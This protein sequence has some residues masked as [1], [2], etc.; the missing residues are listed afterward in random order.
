MSD[1]KGRNRSYVAFECI[2]CYLGLKC[3][4]WWTHVIE[5]LLRNVNIKPQEMNI[6]FKKFQP[7]KFELTGEVLNIFSEGE[8]I[9]MQALS[10][11]FLHIIGIGEFNNA[12]LEFH[13]D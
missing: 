8:T 2:E 12:E 7:N 13:P 9:L 5:N 10:N 4:F 3:I 11:G 6:A 1:F